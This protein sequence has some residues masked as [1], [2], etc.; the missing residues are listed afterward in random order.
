MT[1]VKGTDSVSDSYEEMIRLIEQSKEK[2]SLVRL[3]ILKGRGVRLSI[4]CKILNFDGETRNL[5]VYHV[6]DKQVYLV[7]MREIDD[8]IVFNN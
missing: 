2:G 7:N 3:S 5:S 6:D 8:F 4:P 1:E